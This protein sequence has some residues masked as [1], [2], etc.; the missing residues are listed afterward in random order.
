MPTPTDFKEADKNFAPKYK[1]RTVYVQDEGE[2]RS[3][4]S[5]TSWFGTAEETKEEVEVEVGLELEYLHIWGV[6]DAGGEV[7]WDEGL[8]LEGDVTAKIRE[9]LRRLRG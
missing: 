5:Q 7:V 2:R 4:F 1:N 8:K 9:E 3:L 6:E